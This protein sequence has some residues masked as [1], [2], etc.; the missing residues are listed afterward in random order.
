MPEVS[1]FI[2]KCCMDFQ[3]SLFYK[4]MLYGFSNFSYCYKYN[5][6]GFIIL[7]NHIYD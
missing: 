2:K 5:K 1:C 4:E 3:I 7:F 6:E